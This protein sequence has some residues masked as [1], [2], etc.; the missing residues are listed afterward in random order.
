MERMD[1]SGKGLARQT[2]FSAR[3]ESTNRTAKAP[4]TDFLL[5][6]TLLN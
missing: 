2:K 6:F 1:I 5:I 4:K 3:Q